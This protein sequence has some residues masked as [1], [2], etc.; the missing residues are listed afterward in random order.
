[1]K[2]VEAIR[3]LSALAHP[4]R[5]AVFRLLVRAGPTGVSAGSLATA[6]GI[7]ASTLTFHLKELE[8]S[9]LIETRREGRFIRSALNVP[10]MR[11]LIAFLT[12][13]CCAGRPD[14]CGVISQT[15]SLH[16]EEAARCSPP[17]VL[18]G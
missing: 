8:R 16:E 13:D 10:V 18:K 3:A 7:A 17:R 2:D 14:L 5:L 12:D 4:H 6:A 9:G 1:M 11:D 15:A